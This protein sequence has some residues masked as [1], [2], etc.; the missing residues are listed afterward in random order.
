MCVILSFV[1]RC[2][3]VRALR[4]RSKEKVTLAVSDPFVGD[5]AFRFGA[6]FVKPSSRARAIPLSV[7]RVLAFAENT[8]GTASA[9]PHL[10]LFGRGAFYFFVPS[11]RQFGKLMFIGEMNSRRGG[12]HIRPC[13][14]WEHMECSP[15]VFVRRR[16]VTST[17]RQIKI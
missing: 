16:F 13:K 8:G 10:V 9:I 4:T 5:V 2:D 12:F 14:I 3:E 11:L 1:K 6:G 17:H 15:T 7:A